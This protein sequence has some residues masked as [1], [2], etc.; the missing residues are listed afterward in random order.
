MA[1]KK[2]EQQFLSEDLEPP[3]IEHLDGAIE[4]HQKHKNARCAS[5]EKEKAAK[6][7]IIELMENNSLR[8]YNYDGFIY[9]IEESEKL[10][11]KRVGDD[12]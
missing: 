5:L 10:V 6:I 11:V 4:N 1:K 3:R 12:D 7:M 9:A 2:A 8:S